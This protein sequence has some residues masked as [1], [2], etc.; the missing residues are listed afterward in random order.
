MLKGH[1]FPQRYGEK[2]ITATDA[3][4]GKAGRDLSCHCIKGLAKNITNGLSKSF[5]E[6]KGVNPPQISFVILL[7]KKDYM[8]RFSFVHQPLKK[9]GPYLQT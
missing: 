2:E 4:F 7:I 9:Y 6:L 8:L 3:I 1:D 5:A